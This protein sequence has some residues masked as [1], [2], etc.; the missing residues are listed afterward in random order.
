MVLAVVSCCESGNAHAVKKLAREEGAAVACP[1]GR[2]PSRQVWCI[3]P[4]DNTGPCAV[5]HS[6][7]QHLTPATRRLINCPNSSRCRTNS[8]LVGDR[9][10]TSAARSVLPSSPLQ[11]GDSSTSS[12][13]SVAAVGGA[14]P[15]AVVRCSPLHLLQVHT[16][17]SPQPLCCST[18]PSPPCGLHNIL[19]ESLHE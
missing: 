13:E 18:T 7:A 16:L 3:Q 6:T 17:H 5:Q 4:E 2:Q 9:S 12:S 19:H 15:C 8:P 11:H 10:P 1:D 14:G